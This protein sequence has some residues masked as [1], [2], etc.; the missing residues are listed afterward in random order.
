ME[1]Y[2]LD[3]GRFEVHEA[4]DDSDNDEGL[5]Y[6]C[7][8]IS[9]QH[10][11][12]GWPAL[13]GT[14]WV[15]SPSGSGFALHDARKCAAPEAA[16]LADAMRVKNAL[17]RNAESSLARHGKLFGWNGGKGVIWTPP[18]SL[19]SPQRLM[20][21]GRLVESV[22]GRYM[23]S[24]DQGVGR[25]ELKWIGRATS[26][27]IGLGCEHD[28]GEATAHGVLAGLIRA[29]HQERLVEETGERRL[30]GVRILV[31]GAGKVGLPLLA[32]LREEGADLWVL[33]PAFREYGVEGVFEIGQ[34]RGASVGP[35]HLALLRLLED[36]GRTYEDE[37]EAISNRSIQVISPNGGPTR[38]V[39]DS[40]RLSA[41][42]RVSAPVGCLRLSPRR[43]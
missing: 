30:Q 3:E 14:R 36:Q 41:L 24:E 33:D 10:W 28:T 13:G 38:W 39:S 37:N 17:L 26:Y 18:G 29:A 15:K 1:S 27:T 34:R 2:T 12:T 16:L 6:S 9:R 40:R 11:N 23:A 5:I 19:L 32:M 35:G 42:A 43:W 20:C 31:V 4:F 25:P 21:H 8:V 7:I 22:G